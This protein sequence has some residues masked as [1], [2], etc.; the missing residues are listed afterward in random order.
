V[1]GTRFHVVA[2]P[3]RAGRSLVFVAAELCDQAGTVCATSSG[4]VAITPADST[5][6]MA[7]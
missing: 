5:G 7:L 1:T 2:H 4:M 6:E 3:V